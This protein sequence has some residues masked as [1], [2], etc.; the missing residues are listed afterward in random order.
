MRNEAFAWLAKDK[1]V[2]D[3]KA[4]DSADIR[5]I[6]AALGSHFL[7]TNGAANGDLSRHVMARDGLEAGG[8]QLDEM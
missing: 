8:I 3:C 4:D 2:S 1:V 7:E 6:E 5:L